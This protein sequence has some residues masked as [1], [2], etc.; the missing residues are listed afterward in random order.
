M[1]KLE[2]M[3]LADADAE[4]IFLTIR[5]APEVLG[6]ERLISKIDAFRDMYGFNRNVSFSLLFAALCFAIAGHI[7]GSR[8]LVHFAIAA[9]VAGTLLFYRYLKFFRQYSYELFNS[10]A[11]M[12]GQEYFLM[13]TFTLFDV[14]HGFC[15]YATTPGGANIL[16]DCGYDDDLQ[17]YPSR[18]FYDRGITRISELILSHFDQDHVADLPALKRTLNFDSITRNGTVPAGF[19]RREKQQCGII[20]AAMAT[21]IDMHETWIHP[22]TIQPNYGGVKVTRFHIDYPT[23]TDTNN[24]SVVTFLE[25][26]RCGIVIPGDLER[27]GWEELLKQPAF[28]QC[29]RETTIFIASHH[30]RNAGYSEQVFDHC[31]PHIILLSDKNIMHDTQEHDYTKHARGI[32]WYGRTRRVLTTRSDGHIRIHKEPNRAAGV[33][34]NLVL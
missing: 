24:L 5:Y 18:Y 1:A 23:F 8:P 3:E 22:V 6:S 16:F 31:Q 27:E 9:L 20:T 13:L 29:L 2:S 21:A 15:A 28:C 14:G 26:E 34:T 30:G 10:Y 32:D 17:F 4:D 7:K 19:I 12:S 33:S 25:Y 11:G